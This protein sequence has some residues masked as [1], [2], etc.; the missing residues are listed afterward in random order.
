MMETKKEIWKDIQGFE[1][2]YQVSTY[3][4]VKSLADN[5]GN[6]RELVRKPRLAKNGYLYLSLWSN[7][8][9]CWRKIHRL[10]AETFI[11]NKE[12]LPAVNHKDGN[13][14]NNN[15][16]NL[17]WCSYSGNTKHAIQTG[18]INPSTLF[19]C[20]E[21][22]PMYGKHGKDNPCSKPVLQ[23]DMNGNFIKRWNNVKE[24]TEQTKISH[25]SAVCRKER[26]T[27]GGFLWEYQ[28]EKV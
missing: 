27:A 9:P 12:K 8:T 20:G 1:G 11:E 24:A 26:K 15:I 13:K 19:N 22:N 6:T 7:S 28:L 25:I 23:Y 16:D 3:G 5:Q 10:V 2:K 18:L 14:Q 17:E 4:R 21:L